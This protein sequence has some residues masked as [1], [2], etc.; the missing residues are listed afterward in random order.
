VYRSSFNSR[1][2]DPAR[3]ERNACCNADLGRMLLFPKD[4]VVSFVEGF[5]FLC[6]DSCF[7]ETVEFFEGRGLGVFEP[8]AI[9]VFLSLSLLLAVFLHFQNF[10][11]VFLFTFAPSLFFGAWW[12]TFIITIIC[13]RF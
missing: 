12:C 11:H 5:S 10:S 6:D 7:F 9:V 13:I 3:R 8:P 4:K 1:N 2:L